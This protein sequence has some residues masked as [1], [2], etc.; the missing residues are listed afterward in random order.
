MTPEFKAGARV[1]PEAFSSDGSRVIGSS[2]AVFAGTEGY[3][4]VAEAIYESVRSGTDWVTSA[5][6]PPAS[7]FPAQKLL[8]FNPDLDRGL[9]VAHRASQSINAEDLYIREPDGAFVEVGPI[10]PSY[11]TEGPAAGSSPLL[12]EYAVTVYA[13]ASSDLSHVFFQIRGE[14]PLWTG[15]TTA[16][17]GQL[18]L[19]EYVGTGNAEPMLVGVNNEGHLISDC[20]TSLGLE[21]PGIHNAD[22]Y[23]A[24]SA[25]GETAFFTALNAGECGAEHAP[26]VNEVYA[27]VGV[28]AGARTVAI[29]EP[30]LADC[31]ACQTSERAAAEFAG[32]SRDGS[33][34]FFTTSQE[35]LKGATGENLYEYD[36]HNRPG[37]KIIRISTG[38]ATP[39][40]QG[41]MRVSE[42]GSH[43]Y[44]VAGG[45]LT[46]GPNGEGDEP[47]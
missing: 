14:G 9:W 21:L 8:D 41:V 20:G 15:D 32:A 18:S 30:S 22:T 33:R 1:S 17:N 29:S 13:G 27:R 3:G 4:E 24:I 28:G 43:V 7:L 19:Y 10:V 23:N 16:H 45:V 11:A 2:I 42:D 12:N 31:E 37:H 40:V 47:V 26:A 39:E 34:V 35:L 38:S 25:D 44:F 36:F 6:S 5:I 46:S